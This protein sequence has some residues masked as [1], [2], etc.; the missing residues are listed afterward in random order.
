MSMLPETTPLE[1][2][3]RF[4][5]VT[6]QNLHAAAKIDSGNGRVSFLNGRGRQRIDNSF[7]AVEVCTNDGEVTV[8]NTNGT[9]MFVTIVLGIGLEIGD[10]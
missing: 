3:N 9:V 8:V 7:G 10:G 1:L 4:G 2:R 6:G 5:A